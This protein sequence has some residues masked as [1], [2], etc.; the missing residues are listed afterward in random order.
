MTT[1]DMDKAIAEVWALFKATD[2]KIEKLS[3]EVSNV[4]KNVGNLTD[5]WGKFVENFV[6]PGIPAAFTDR[7]IKISRVIQRVK[8]TDAK[9]RILMEI[10][11]LAVNTDCVILIEVKSTLKVKDVDDHIERIKKIRQK[12][13]E[14]KYK[15]DY[16]AVAGVEVAS[17]ADDYAKQKGLFILTVGGDSVAIA[18]EPG[19]QA[20]AW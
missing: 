16:G 7:G 14:Y 4:S 5:K 6:V 19:F 12:F 17:S 13:T 18:N 8:A 15:N 3:K 9:G 11:H 2:K 1:E 10:D 20:V